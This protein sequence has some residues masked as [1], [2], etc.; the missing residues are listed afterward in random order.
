[1]KLVLITFL[2]IATNFRSFAKL[3][4][5]DSIIRDGEG[6]ALYLN[7][8]IIIKFHPDLVD[9]SIV[10][11]TS[12]QTGIVSDFINP[13]ALQMIIDSGFFNQGLADLSIK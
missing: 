10:N 3:S 9:T 8:Q 2:L 6:N 12:I 1:M 5:E 11:N 7:D 13:I 4:T